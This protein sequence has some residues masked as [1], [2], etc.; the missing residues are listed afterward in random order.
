MHVQTDKRENISDHKFCFIT[1]NTR[2]K[3]FNNSK[4]KC[5]YPVRLPQQL[6][7]QHSPAPVMRFELPTSPKPEMRND[8][9]KERWKYLNLTIKTQWLGQCAKAAI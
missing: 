8:D 9:I 5:V 6:H 2:V 7:Q 4:E 3:S 1:F